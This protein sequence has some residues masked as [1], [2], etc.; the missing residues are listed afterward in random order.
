MNAGSKL[1]SAGFWLSLTRG[2]E[3]ILKFVFLFALARFLSPENIGMYGLVMAITMVVEGIT[4]TGLKQSIIQSTKSVAAVN[5]AIWLTEV[6]KAGFVYLMLVLLSSFLDDFF[7]SDLSSYLA[8]AAMSLIFKSLT[9][10]ETVQRLKEIDFRSLFVVNIAGSVFESLIGIVGVIF[11]NSI[12]W[13]IIAYPLRYLI[14]C[15]CSYFFIKRPETFQVVFK[16]VR[17]HLHFGKWVTLTH[18]VFILSMHLD[19]LFTARVIGL[20]ALGYY[21]TAFKYSN[22]LIMEFALL[23]GYFLFPVFSSIKDQLSERI[24]ILK[25]MID[26]SSAFVAFLTFY[27]ILMAPELILVGLGKRWLDVILIFR[28]LCV[29][30]FAR[31]ISI[32]FGEYYKGM[33]NPKVSFWLNTIRLITLTALIFPLSSVFQLTGVALSA[34]I[35]VLVILP[36]LY[37]FN[38]RH[39][40]E[41]NKDLYTLIL[42]N[43]ACSASAAGLVL[44]VKTYFPSD[45][46]YGLIFYSAVYFVIHLLLDFLLYRH[47]RQGLI[48]SFLILLR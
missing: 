3:K 8:V 13:A 7:K 2:L 47:K 34:L 19:D 23:I 12:W 11:F 20:E 30:A 5:N 41:N 1:K 36:V 46:I 28:I 18:I 22:L 21:Q 48:Y 37:Y 26:L 44:I 10:I 25:K 29:L 32:L 14:T 4:E 6:L 31:S 42:M 45:S 9:N 24:R 39:F 15:I 17:R 35:S 16:G 43:T 38:V 33:G 40:K 27:M